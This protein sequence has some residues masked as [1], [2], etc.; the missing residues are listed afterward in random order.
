MYLGPFFKRRGEILFFFLSRSEC[1]YKFLSLISAGS[2][3]SLERRGSNRYCLKYGSILGGYEDTFQDIFTSFLS[4]RYL[5][6]ISQQKPLTGSQAECTM[7][8]FLSNFY[9]LDVGGSII[10][11]FL[12][13]NESQ[14]VRQSIISMCVLLADV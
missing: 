6:L 3:T 12:T 11:S 9:L 8:N 14:R 10:A 5:S 2:T 4:P 1:L 13:V 7:A